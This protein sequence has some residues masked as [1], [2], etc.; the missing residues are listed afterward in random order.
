M[1]LCWQYDCYAVA[2]NAEVSQSGKQHVME[3]VVENG[4]R[5]DG[6]ISHVTNQ[7]LSIDTLRHG[8][9]TMGH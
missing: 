3:V 7:S 4:W 6:C 8:K 5:E 2:V 9:I 1:L